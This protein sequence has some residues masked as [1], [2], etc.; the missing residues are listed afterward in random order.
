LL[1]TP[2]AAKKK[3]E[4]GQK[5]GWMIGIKNTIHYSFF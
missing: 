1:F 4:E 3:T 5:K 2:A